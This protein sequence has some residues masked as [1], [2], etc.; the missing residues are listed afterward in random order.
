M[1]K[2]TARKRAALIKKSDLICK[3]SITRYVILVHMG[4]KRIKEEQKK[5][6]VSIGIEKS[7][8]EEV[9]KNLGEEGNFSKLVGQLLKNWYEKEK[10]G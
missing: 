1:K 2:K 6:T 5:V 7:L 8:L 3:T 4:R 9:K 10:K